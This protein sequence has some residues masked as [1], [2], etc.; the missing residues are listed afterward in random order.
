[1]PGTRHQDTTENLNRHQTGAVTQWMWR[2]HMT[3]RDLSC[4]VLHRFMFQNKKYVLLNSE[5]VQSNFFIFDHV[6]F[7]QFKIC[8]CVQNFTEIGWFFIEIWRYIDFKNGGRPPFWNCFTTIRDQPQSL[9]CCRS[10]LSNFMSIWYTD[11]QMYYWNFSHI[12]LE[13]SIQAPKMGV[14]DP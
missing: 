5:S 7:I 14:L 13:M 3:A 8:C 9:C 11:L 4:L 2:H 6:T 1:M 12:W 10:C